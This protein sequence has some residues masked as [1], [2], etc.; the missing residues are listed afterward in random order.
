MQLVRMHHTNAVSWLFMPQLIERARKFSEDHQLDFT[1][2]LIEEAIRVH[3]ISNIPTLMSWV[4]LDGTKVI[5]H[6]V[7][8]VDTLADYSGNVAKRH[9][10]IVQAESKKPVPGMMDELKEIAKANYCDSIKIL[11]EG[12]ARI[13]LFKR[14]GFEPRKS[15]MQLSLED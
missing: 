8:T 13:R 2:D 15:V 1:P 7:A 12:P 5:G 14:Y 9:L 6:L 3:F 11:A 4:Y 10:T